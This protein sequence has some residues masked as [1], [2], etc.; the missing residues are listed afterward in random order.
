[1]LV[2]ACAALAGCHKAPDCEAAISSL[3]KRV[4][5]GDT[6]HRAASAACVGQAFSAARDCLADADAEPA[7]QAC[8]AKE[9]SLADATKRMAALRDGAA[10]WTPAKQAEAS[11]SSRSIRKR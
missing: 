2:V 1:M 6:A 10:A 8:I 11:T 9:P 3:V 4:P 5:F 7:L